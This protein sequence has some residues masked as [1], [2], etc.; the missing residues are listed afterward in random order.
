MARQDLTRRAT[1]AMDSCR[2][3]M[4]RHWHVALLLLCLVACILPAGSASEKVASEIIGAPNT[5]SLF[6][7]KCDPER[8]LWVSTQEWHYYLELPAQKVLLDSFLS[9]VSGTSAYL[10]FGVNA[11]RKKDS[12][13]LF[14]YIPEQA[15]DRYSVFFPQ[16][17]KAC[18][19]S[20]ESL[21][22]DSSSPQGPRLIGILEPIGT[23]PQGMTALS[24]ICGLGVKSSGR[25][26]TDVCRTPSPVPDIK[27]EEV[28]KFARNI[29][30]GN[31]AAL[32]RIEDVYL[33][34]PERKAYLLVLRDASRKWL[35]VIERTSGGLAAI[36]FLE[37]GSADPADTHDMESAAEGTCFDSWHTEVFVLPDLNGNGSNEILVRG[38]VWRV[39]DGQ[40]RDPV[41]ETKGCV[42]TK[43]KEGYWGP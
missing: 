24:G 31:A 9:V 29:P 14:G 32:E 30:Q 3:F 41:D 37:P 28:L 21:A 2:G 5:L 42:F 39:F 19:F 40:F 8:W 43:V 17:G 38:T 25:V 11:L 36:P 33:S 26:A 10:E 22:V 7:P 16:L 15:G 6:F 12:T 4:K 18:A 34:Y 35:A 20:L 1:D 27:V 13:E 23:L